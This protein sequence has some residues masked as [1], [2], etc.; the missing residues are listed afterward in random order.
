MLDTIDRYG[1]VL[2]AGL[3]T[4]IVVSLG[5]FVI[6]NALGLIVALMR[7]SP[8]APLRWIAGLYVD[9]LR[10]VPL[11]AALL[12]GFYVLPM[13]LG[14]RLDAKTAGTLVLGI[15]AGAYFAEL[16]RAGIN[17]VPVG[18]REAALAQ[19]MTPVT[20]MRRIV[21]PQAVRRMLPPLTGMTVTLVKDSSLV[22]ILG[23]TD[24]IYRSN[25]IAAVTLDPLPIVTLTG[26][27]YAAITL[28][29]TL[30]GNHMHR[31]FVETA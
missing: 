7:L 16:Y 8:V 6:A 3:W 29:L 12:F 13:L 10:A 18:Q 15:A 27:L 2:L 5:A 21:L 14:L 1:D 9:A 24:L 11:I 19:G 20:A 25:S 28:P 30:A 4:T 23:V 31:R 26:L 22:S 17:T